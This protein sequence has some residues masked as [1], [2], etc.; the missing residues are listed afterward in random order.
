MVKFQW[1][2]PGFAAHQFFKSMTFEFKDNYMYTHSNAWKPAL[3]TL[4]AFT[5]AIYILAYPPKYRKLGIALL[6]IPVTYAFLWQ[7]YLSASSSLNDTYG[8]FLYIWFANMS[9]EVTILEYSPRIVKENDGWKSRVREAYKVLFARAHS[10]KTVKGQTVPATRVPK[11]NYTKSQF[12]ARHAWKTF[13]L[14]ALQCAYG[15]LTDLYINAD[16]VYG[17]D[18]AIF[19]RRLPASLNADELWD[20]TDLVIYWCVINMWMY[21]SYH[22]AFAVFFVALGL[23]DPQDWSMTLFGAMSEAWSV[24]RY[25]GKHWH[26]YI[27]HSFSGHA[28]IV[29]RQWLGMRHGLAR[30]L[31]ENTMVFGVSGLMHSAVRYAQNGGMG[32]DC[33]VISFWYLGQMVPIVIEGVVQD[34]WAR[35]KKQ[36]GIEDTKWLVRAEKGLG[37]AWVIGFNMWSVSKYVHTR[38]DWADKAWRKKYAK[39]LKDWDA[40]R[41]VNETSD[42]IDVDVGAL[43]GVGEKSEL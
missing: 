41:E 33:W 24:R 5:Y 30:R 40:K 17:A 10:D 31:L 13:S 35:F 16:T 18:K 26:D 43:G 25:W 32:G 11:H 7:S 21:E 29:T 28:K 4:V 8:R 38:N 42:I 9:Y 36:R 23:D 34:L 27:Y 6:A 2:D 22:S 19:F 3:A 14:F 39:K 15:I 1:A 20:R 12:L 37:Y